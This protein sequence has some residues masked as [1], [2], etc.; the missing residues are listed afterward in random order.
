[1]NAATPEN[2]PMTEEISDSIERVTVQRSVSLFL[3]SVRTSSSS[4]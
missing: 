1:M 4:R 3:C 2:K